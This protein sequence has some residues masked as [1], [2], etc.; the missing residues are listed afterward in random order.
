MIATFLQKLKKNH[1]K[2]L[3]LYSN[4]Q[5]LLAGSCYW[6]GI[7]LKS[8]DWLVT[9]FWQSHSFRF[10]YKAVHNKRR[11]KHTETGAFLPNNEKLGLWRNVPVRNFCCVKSC[12]VFP[13]LVVVS[14]QCYWY[15][16]YCS[17]HMTYK[18]ISSVLLY[19]N[20]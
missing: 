16:I 8:K 2:Y 9:Y 11:L 14:V 19:S 1:L 17:W 12:V 6:I 10:Y 13:C 3:N 5:S 4:L 18:A 7:F 15:C 20:H